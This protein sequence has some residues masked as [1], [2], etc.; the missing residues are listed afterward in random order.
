MLLDR[1]PYKSD[2][3]VDDSINSCSEHPTRS[4]KDTVITWQ[5]DKAYNVDAILLMGTTQKEL[6]L[7]EF[8]LYVG[9]SKN[10]EENTACPNGPFA[11]PV[12]ET[13]GTYFDDSLGIGSGTEWPNGVEAWCNLPGN[14]VSF[15]RKA[16]A[17]PALDRVVLCTFGVIA[18]TEHLP[19]QEAPTN[20]DRVEGI[21]EKVIVPPHL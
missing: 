15:V 17:Q 21:I 5:L 2:Y 7:S 3:T 4:G 14:F 8:D 1:N 12:D 19:R 6:Q 11:Y 10:Y 16:S 13:Y 18:D 9:Y 20:T